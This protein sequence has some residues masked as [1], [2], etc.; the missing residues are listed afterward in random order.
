MTM[1]TV[2]LMLALAG[3][4]APWAEAAPPPDKSL[5]AVGKPDQGV[6]GLNKARRRADGAL[7][8]EGTLAGHGVVA[9]KGTRV[10]QGKVAPGNSPGCV[11]DQ[12]NVIFEGT[13]TLEIEI[14]GPTACT[15]FDRYSVALSLTLNGPT[16]NVLLINGFVPTAGQRFNVLDWGTLSGTFGAV[17][18]PALPTGLQWD[19]A[20][21]YTTGELVV[22]GPAAGPNDAEVP[23]P[24]WAVGLLGAGLATGLARRRRG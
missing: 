4:F 7:I 24:I 9:G 14:G 3:L 19:T 18:L 11:T 20:A 6:T 22:N 8:V 1:K 13:A 2:S 15:Q 5:P 17:N 16:L 12:G 10:I 23:L 21:L